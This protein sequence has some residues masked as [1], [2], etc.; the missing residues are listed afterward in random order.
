[1]ER[2]CPSAER[3]TLR[4]S[5]AWREADAGPGLDAFVSRPRKE[6]YSARPDFREDILFSHCP[7]WVILREIFEKILCG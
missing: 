3:R 2:W 7:V 5:S 4:T 6:F 1:M